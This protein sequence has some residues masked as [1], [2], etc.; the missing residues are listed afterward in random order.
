VLKNVPAFYGTQRSLPC[1]QDPFIGPNPV[2]LRS[3]LILYTHLR[4]C[5]PSGLFPSGFPT[6]LLHALLLPTIRATCLAHLILRDL[7]V[8]S[9]LG[10]EYKLWSSSLC[11]FLQ[12]PIT[13]SLVGPNIVL[14]TLFSTPSVYVSPLMP[15]TKFHTHTNPHTKLWF[16]IF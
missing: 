9:I 13:S 7:I 1:S 4:Q 6:K 11:S 2:S 10:E 3:I 15:D 8:L 16:C 12:S 5:L 14:S